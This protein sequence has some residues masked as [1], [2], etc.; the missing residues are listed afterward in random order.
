MS[1]SMGNLLPVTAEIAYC[2]NGLKTLAISSFTKL[3]PKDQVKL[4]VIG[5]V[6]Y[7]LD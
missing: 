6:L 3:R 1:C 2:E 7:D 4:K 5:E